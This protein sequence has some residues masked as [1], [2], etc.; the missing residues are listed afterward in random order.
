MTSHSEQPSSN[1]RSMDSN[2]LTGMRTVALN[3]LVEGQT[4]RSDCVNELCD[5]ILRLQHVNGQLHESLKSM[6]K[7][8]DDW[9]D[10]CQRLQEEKRLAL[11]ALEQATK[12]HALEPEVGTLE[13][14]FT[15]LIAE[16]ER[17]FG[18]E[19]QPLSS[20]PPELRILGK[21]DASS[22][23][24]RAMPNS[25]RSHK[26]GPRC[27]GHNCIG[28]PFNCYGHPYDCGCS[29]STKRL[30]PLADEDGPGEEDGPWAEGWEERT[31][32]KNG[33][34]K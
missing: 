30:A 13:Y 15:S 4:S 7:S 10:E 9:Q 8:C 14:R 25:A 31:G 22:Q 5:E 1:T 24:P 34:G 29:A 28:H 20:E 23:P 32:T 33:E 21:L 3:L 17:R 16:L 2:R 12:Q 19:P 27:D 6:H 18:V 26:P 11:Y